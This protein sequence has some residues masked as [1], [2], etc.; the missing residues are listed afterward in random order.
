MAI[1]AM[2]KHAQWWRDPKLVDGFVQGV[3]EGG[4][5]KGVLYVGA[6]KALLTRKLWFASVAG[7]SAGAITA[8]MIAA[9]MHPDHMKQEMDRGLVAM[10]LP[11]AWRGLRRVRQ[12]HGFLDR[13][14]IR[15]WLR[16]LLLHQC[17]AA[18]FAPHSDDGPTF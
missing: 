10:A 4:G 18:G 9:G 16:C 7:S 12:G 13:E 8:A 1:G 3:F 17:R 2:E 11:P 5:T 14:K 6:L 15:S